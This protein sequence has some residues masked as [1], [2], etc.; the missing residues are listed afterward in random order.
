M[1]IE[2]RTRGILFY[3]FALW[4]LEK[5]MKRLRVQTRSGR[6]WKDSGGLF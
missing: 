3:R 4:L 1:T 2:V 6:K 5:A